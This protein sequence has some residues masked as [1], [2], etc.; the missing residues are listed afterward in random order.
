MNEIKPGR[1]KRDDESREELS[2]LGVPL[3]VSIKE[4]LE[5]YCL[6]D[7]C[8]MSRRVRRYIIEGM[9]RDGLDVEDR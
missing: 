2:T 7:G 9:Q 4:Q 5:L 1:P 6:K 3:P 8:P